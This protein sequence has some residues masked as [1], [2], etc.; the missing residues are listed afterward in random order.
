MNKNK[1]AQ[2]IVIYVIGV[3]VL[4][5]GVVLNTKC[6]LG[7]STTNSVPFVVSKITP[8]TLGMSCTIVYLADVAFQCIVYRKI[9]LKV[10]LQFPFSFVFG[11]IVDFYNRFIIITSPDLGMKILLLVLGIVF[12]AVGISM[13]VN[14]DFVP[15]PPDGGVQ[16]LAALT[17]LPFGRAKWLYDGVLLAITLVISL[18]VAHTIIGIGIGTVVAFFTIGNIVHFI[19]VHFGSF[20]KSVYDKE[21]AANKAA[22]EVKS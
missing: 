5:L 19:N 17:K 4:A 6:A 8:L 13:V 20:F 21:A 16:A 3:L 2:R 7:V 9:R 10:L 1:M 22:Q 15:N 14:M 18:S 11:W 12:T